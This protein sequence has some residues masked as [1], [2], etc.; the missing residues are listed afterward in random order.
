VEN[1]PSVVLLEV[2]LCPSLKIIRGF[3]RMQMVYIESCPALEML[4]AGAALGNVTLKDPKMESLPEYLRG[5]NP[6]IL[7]VVACHQNLRELLL[8]PSSDGCSSANDKY[9][10]EM[11]KVKLK[12]GGKLVV[13]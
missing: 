7:R 11:D 8:W 6:R 1:F 4:E 13:L 3:S 5:L 10:A 12:Q 2:S 9:Q